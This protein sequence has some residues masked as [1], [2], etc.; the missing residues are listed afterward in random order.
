MSTLYVVGLPLGN[1][2]DLGERARE[3]LSRVAVIATEDTRSFSH[4]CQRAGISLEGKRIIALYREKEVERSSI[5]VKE[6]SKTDVALVSEAGMPGVS[7]PGG[8]TVSLA[9]REGHCVT[10]VPGPS[11]ITTAL[12]V[13]GYTGSRFYF[14]GFLPHKISDKVREVKE[15]AHMKPPVAVVF[16]ES[17]ERM[18]ETIEVIAQQYPR[19]WCC[20]ASNLTKKDEHIVRA[21]IT[22]IE[23]RE[24]GE[25]T[26]V[27]EF[28]R[29]DILSS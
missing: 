13:S 29:H 7:D 28:A 11:A 4:L 19:V 18:K 5:V 12:S 9:H 26:V 16:F 3:V 22:E 17:K 14:A 10:P 24:E 27:I 23:A 15:W 6:L 21:R 1:S 25:Y 2:A 8:Y 20:V